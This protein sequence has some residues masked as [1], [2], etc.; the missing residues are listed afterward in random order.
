MSFSGRVTSH[1]R[2]VPA[3]FCSMKA[4]IE[5]GKKSYDRHEINH[6]ISAVKAGHWSSGKLVAQF[7]RRF[8]RYL[9]RKYCLTTNSGSSANLLAITA[10][11]SSRL[12][13]KR[14]K[15][16]DEIITL[17]AGFPTT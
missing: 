13:S 8:A 4:W 3:V 9:D 7:E 6:V 11:T 1:L 10:L 14:L 16:G 2:M 12:G 17:A 15:P 5:V